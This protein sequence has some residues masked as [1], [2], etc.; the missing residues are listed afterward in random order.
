MRV[1]AALHQPLTIFAANDL[2]DVVSPD[3]DNANGR[4][5]SIYTVVSPCSR[6]VVLRARI[7]A[8][9]TTH[10]PPA[11]CGGTP[12]VA[13][14]M[15][16]GSCFCARRESAQQCHRRNDSTHTVVLRSCRVAVPS[17]DTAARVWPRSTEVP[18]AVTPGKRRPQPRDAATAGCRRAP[19][20]TEN[21]TVH[22]AIP[23]KRTTDL[24]LSPIGATTTSLSN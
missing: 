23:I 7:A 3:D 6:E 17:E 20:I 13:A 24:R 18:V 14:V 22:R 16:L 2:A 19:K 11:P 15:M 5:T 1:I 4:T 10:V 12:S 9:L 21:V 8:H